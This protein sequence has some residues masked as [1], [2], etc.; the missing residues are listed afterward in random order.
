[1]TEKY[2]S[3]CR[4]PQWRSGDKAH[5]TADHKG[6]GDWPTA[7]VPVKLAM[8]DTPVAT[9]ESAFSGLD[10]NPETPITPVV[11]VNTAQ[12]S[13]TDKP[14]GQLFLQPG[15]M[16]YVNSNDS[17]DVVFPDFNLQNMSCDDDDS[18]FFDAGVI[19]A[20]DI[21]AELLVDI[22]DTESEV[23]SSEPVFYDCVSSLGEGEDTNTAVKTPDLSDET[24]YF[25]LFLT[26]S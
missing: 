17:G 19:P 13:H 21:Y 23:S 22:P 12:A 24:H 20:S 8:V 11:A 2:C 7:K 14:T 4:F 6:R 26:I 10:L 15:L 25:H 9:I 5:V 18:L 16:C 3:K 1:M